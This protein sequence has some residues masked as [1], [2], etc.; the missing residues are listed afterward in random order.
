M[1][2]PCF[3]HNNVFKNLRK[4]SE[5]S[6]KHILKTSESHLCANNVLS[7]CTH[8]TSFFCSYVLLAEPFSQTWHL[9]WLLFCVCAPLCVCHESTSI[10]QILTWKHTW[11]VNF[12]AMATHKS[13]KLVCLWCH[14]LS[15]S[16]F[17][18]HA[19]PIASQTVTSLQSHLHSFTHTSHECNI[20]TVPTE[21]LVFGRDSFNLF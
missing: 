4:C 11:F 13:H 20:L 3:C 18:S 19:S 15:L 7:E 17:S 1:S 12:I 21:L 6:W 14:F 2:L 16:R 5:V 10:W 8:M 9:Q